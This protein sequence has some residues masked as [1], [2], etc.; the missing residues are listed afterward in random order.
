MPIFQTKLKFVRRLSDIGQTA[1]WFDS[2]LIRQTILMTATDIVPPAHYLESQIFRENK[3]V[4]NS[5]GDSPNTHW[6]DDISILHTAVT[7]AYYSNVKIMS[8]RNYGPCSELLI[9]RHIGPTAYWSNFRTNG[10][11]GRQAVRMQSIPIKTKTNVKPDDLYNSSA[12][13]QRVILTVS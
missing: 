3:F 9:K 13:R 11:S 5:R 1:N 12:Y 4:E 10:L 8:C 7:P 2:S 6:S